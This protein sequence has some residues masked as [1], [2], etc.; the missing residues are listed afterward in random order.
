MPSIHQKDVI[1]NLP[2]DELQVSLQKF[3]QPITDL[4]PD[5]R[6]CAVAELMIQGVVARQSPIVTRIARHALHG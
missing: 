4:L 3:L 6:L 1:A 2:A 5:V